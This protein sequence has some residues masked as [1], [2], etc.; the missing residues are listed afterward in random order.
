MKR[1]WVYIVLGV[2]L[3][4]NAGA[5]G[6]ILYRRYTRWHYKREF[7]RHI[8]RHVRHE[9]SDLMEEHRAEMDSLRL[10]F[11]NAKY[12]LLEL[13]LKDSVDTGEVEFQLDRIANTY[14]EMTR[15]VHQT[16]RKIQEVQP[17]DKRKWL[18]RR[19]REMM[20]DPNRERRRGRRSRGY[21]RHWGPRSHPDYYG[22]PACDESLAE[23]PLPPGQGN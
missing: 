15:L 4:L 13:G 14:R 23:P 1:R 10:E 20:R 9:V 11:H 18:R 7:T 22:P 6:A 3:G 8:D 16:G 21:Y 17:K 2:S 19:L 12:E 5:I